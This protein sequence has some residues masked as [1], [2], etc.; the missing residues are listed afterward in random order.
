MLATDAR[1]NRVVVGPRAEL[2]TRDGARCAARGCTARPT[3]STACKLRYRSRPLPCT[4]GAGR[5]DGRLELELGEPVDGAAPGQAACLL[6]GDVVVGWARSRRLDLAWTGA[7]F[8]GADDREAVVPGPIRPHQLDV[9]HRRAVPGRAITSRSTARESNRRA[10]R[11][12]RRRPVADHAGEPELRRDRRRRADLFF[13]LPDFRDFKGVP[14][15]SVLMGILDFLEHMYDLIDPYVS[16]W[17][18][19]LGPISEDTA[20]EMSRLTGGLS[21]TVGDITGELELD[22]D[23]TARGPRRRLKRLVVILH[24]RSQQGLQRAGVLMVGHAPLPRDRAVRPDALGQRA[25]RRRGA[26]GVRARLLAH[27]ATDVTGHAV[28]NAISGGPFRTHWQR[29]HLVG[30]PHRRYWYLLD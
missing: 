12:R 16:K 9:A 30:E 23:H 4:V 18:H 10:G 8:V 17:E 14:V 15:A 28:V 13:F 2:A 26:A 19:Y 21:E 20:E 6:R 5:G 7:G 3:R 22:A 1:S 11:D 29:H 27:L 25:G 24:P